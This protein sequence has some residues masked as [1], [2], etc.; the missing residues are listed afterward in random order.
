MSR[1]ERVSGYLYLA[2]SSRPVF[3]ARLTVMKRVRILLRR[4]VSASAAHNFSL[5]H[6]R[7]RFPCRRS[8]RGRFGRVRRRRDTALL[9]LWVGG[10]RA[11]NLMS[12]V[13]CSMMSRLCCNS[14]SP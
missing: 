2:S 6:W 11:R 4:T 1:P 3:G 14:S 9:R 8:R 5:N 13:F 7:E 12:N 10:R